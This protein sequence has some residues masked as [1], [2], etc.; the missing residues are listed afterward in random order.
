[1]VDQPIV[2][3][4]ELIETIERGSSVALSDISSIE[5][6]LELIK[7]YEDQCYDLKEFKRQK[8]KIISEEIEL[9]EGKIG[10]IRSIIAETLKTAKKKSVKFPGLG[11]AS[12]NIRKGSWDI[13]DEEALI[14]ILKDEGEDDC[15]EDKT[16]L[17]KTPLNKLLNIWLDI[18]KIPKDIAERGKERD[19]ITITFEKPTVDVSSIT[20]VK[21]SVDELDIDA[22]DFSNG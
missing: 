12:H 21:K 10:F 1:M 18:D 14:K 6:A 2:G 13:K 16:S 3:M 15:Y 22:I 19:S 11:K 5:S 17:K 4:K 7:K 20:V 9:V 8:T